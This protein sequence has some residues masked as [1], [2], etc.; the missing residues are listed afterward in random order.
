MALAARGLGLGTL[1]TTLLRRSEAE[2][3][4]IL[5]VP[6]GAEFV[7]MLPVGYPDA[8]FGP[9]RRLPVEEVTYAERWGKAWG[10]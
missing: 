7:C 9:V 6:D 4:R 2:V 10:K 5:G 8:K 1:F 3:K